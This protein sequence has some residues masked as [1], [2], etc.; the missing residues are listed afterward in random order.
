MPRWEARQK[1]NEMQEYKDYKNSIVKP[2][3]FNPQP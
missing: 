3:P 1:V 2:Q